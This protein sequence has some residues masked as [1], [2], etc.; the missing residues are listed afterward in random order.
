MAK[1]A[2]QVY[3]IACLGKLPALS[4]ANVQRFEPGEL[5]QVVDM[6]THQVVQARPGRRGGARGAIHIQNVNAYHRRLKNWM[7]RFHGVARRYLPNY[8]GWR[9]MLER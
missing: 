7:A 4:I 5:R 3:S 9:H 1:A 2:L 6:L 8:L